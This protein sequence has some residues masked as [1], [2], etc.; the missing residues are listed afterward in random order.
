M[1]HN[2]WEEEQ[3]VKDN[4]KVVSLHSESKGFSITVDQQKHI[5]EICPLSLASYSYLNENKP[6]IVHLPLE[7]IV[8]KFNKNGYYTILQILKA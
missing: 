2:W 8:K 5:L 6:G 7:Q 3:W 1:S 4:V